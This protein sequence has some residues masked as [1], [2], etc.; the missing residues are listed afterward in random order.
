MGVVKII[1]D[2]PIHL[3]YTQLWLVQVYMLVLIGIHFYLY[4]KKIVPLYLP[5]V[6]SFHY[7]SLIVQT[8]VDIPFYPNTIYTWGYRNMYFITLTLEL[9]FWCFYLYQKISAIKVEND[10]LTQQLNHHKT[11][12]SRQEKSKQFLLLRSKAIISISELYYIKSDDKY[13]EIFTSKGHEIDRNSLKNI[14]VQLKGT[15]CIRIHKSYIVNL[16]HV[17]AVYSTKLLLDNGITLP[18]SRS[19]KAALLLELS[20]PSAVY[21][22]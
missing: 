8:T 5:L 15:N 13:I 12:V 18:L 10:W 1:F 17:R 3:F 6:F 22:Q 9:C 14:L 11:M 16:L 20:K 21:A 2:L 4:Q 7:L 19:F